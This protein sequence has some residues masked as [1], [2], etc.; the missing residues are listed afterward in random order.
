MTEMQAIL[1]RAQLKILDNQ[2]KKRNAIAN[3][4]LNGLKNYYKKNNIL[5]KINFSFLYSPK[6]KGKKYTNKNIHAFYRLNLF[7][8]NKK[9]NQLKLLKQ[10]NQKNINCGVGSCPEIYREKVFK[11]LKLHP[12]KRLSNAKLLG[13][14]RTTFPIDLMRFREDR[15]RVKLSEK[16]LINTYNFMYKKYFKDFWI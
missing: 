10:L 15:I 9:I 12:K 13:E 11:K 4:Y 1:G 16:F 2:I 14:T 7:I 8:N 5:K 6:I 3:L